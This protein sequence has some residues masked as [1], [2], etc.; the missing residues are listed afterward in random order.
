MSLDLKLVG[1][2]ALVTGASR[3]CQSS[4]RALR[5]IGGLADLLR[6]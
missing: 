4:G 6:S 3:A 5:R 2:V 1:R